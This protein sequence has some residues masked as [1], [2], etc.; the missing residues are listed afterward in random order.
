M[1]GGKVCEALPFIFTFINQV[2]SGEFFWEIAKIL[3]ELTELYGIVK[4]DDVYLHFLL[5]QWRSQR[6]SGILAITRP[7]FKAHLEF[8]QSPG[9]H[10]APFIFTFMY[11]VGSGDCQNFR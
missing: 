4:K 2:G 8:W 7:E 10:T 6:S 9:I 3:G 1:L 11:K 5:L